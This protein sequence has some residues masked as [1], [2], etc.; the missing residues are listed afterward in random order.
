MIWPAAFAVAGA[1]SRHHFLF[2]ETRLQITAFCLA[3][4]AVELFYLVAR[5]PYSKKRLLLNIG[6]A[7]LAIV[8]ARWIVEAPPWIDHPHGGY[9][10]RHNQNRN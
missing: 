10:P 2:V 5:L 1:A 6:W 7:T 9:V 4:I 3:A 8:A